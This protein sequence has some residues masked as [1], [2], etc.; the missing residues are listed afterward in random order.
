M[1]FS[2]PGAVSPISVPDLLDYSTAKLGFLL[3]RS[4]FKMVLFFRHSSEYVV[5][6]NQ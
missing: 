5:L 6:I 1:F 2:V 3:G 4:Q